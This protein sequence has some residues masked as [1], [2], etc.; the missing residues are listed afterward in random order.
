[1]NLASFIEFLLIGGIAGWIAGLITK[2]SGFGVG[3]NI[4]VGIIGALLG[5]L[6]FGLLGIV[7]YGLVGRLIFAVLGSLLFFWL[8]GL[9][10]KR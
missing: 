1:M 7:A 3:G 9:I 8:L 10:R 2:G 6:C 5:G 4:V